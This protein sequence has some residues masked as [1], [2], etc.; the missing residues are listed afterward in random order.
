MPGINF[1]HST[2][3]I[4]PTSPVPLGQVERADRT[5]RSLAQ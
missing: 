5:R 1:S 3:L 4:R 2:S